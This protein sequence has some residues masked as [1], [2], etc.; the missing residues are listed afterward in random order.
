MSSERIVVKGRLCRVFREDIDGDYWSI[1]D[2]YGAWL[3]KSGEW[4]SGTTDLIE[5]S[6]RTEAAALAFA[7]EYADPV[8]NLY[9]PDFLTPADSA[10][11]AA[12]PRSTNIGKK[13]PE[14]A[15]A[16]GEAGAQVR[17]VGQV[18]RP[19]APDREGSIPSGSA[20]LDVEADQQ[21]TPP[22]AGRELLPCPFCGGE[23]EEA[24]ATLRA[25]GVRDER[26]GFQCRKCGAF[27]Y[28]VDWNR[29]YKAGAERE[30]ITEDDREETTESHLR[31]LTAW[32]RRCVAAETRLAER[33][34]DA[35]LALAGAAGER[36]ADLETKF[37]H[38]FKSRMDGT[39]TCAKCGWDLRDEIHERVAPSTEPSDAQS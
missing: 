27:A 13:L 39:D 15:A 2:D 30:E 38:T 37:R 20:A 16:I 23:P 4:R 14:R 8:D 10:A 7:R 32:K 12:L 25:I 19:L 33:E 9:S 5:G 21:E 31:C 6:W 22:T 28:E 17:P 26:S 34:R 1:R 29:R 36:V 3:H 18:D 35:A 11:L 24:I